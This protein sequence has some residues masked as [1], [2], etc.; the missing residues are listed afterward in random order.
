MKACTN[1]EHHHVG[2]DAGHL[3]GDRRE[4]RHLGREDGVVDRLHAGALEDLPRH[5]E[6]GLG[7]RVV[8]GGVCRRLR[9]LRRGQARHPLRP[10]HQV[11]LDRD[12]H[13]EHVL[14]PRTEHRRTAAGPLHEGVAVAGGHARGREREQR[15]ERAEHEL[16]LV[17]GDQL[18][19]V[20]HDLA[21]ARGV[22]EDLELD[23]VPH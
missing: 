6:L 14:Q 23:L 7:E 3:G 1:A 2:L 12:R 8:G 20:A 19:V 9:A 22:G 11:V 17:G 16:V 21:R 15:R 4:V 5:R 13:V 18:L 10:G